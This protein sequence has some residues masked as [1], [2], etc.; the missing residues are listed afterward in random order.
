MVQDPPAMTPTASYQIAL[1][2]PTGTA[3]SGMLRQC[4]NDPRITRVVAVTRRSLPVAHPKLEEVICQDFADLEPIAL[5]LTHIDACFYALGIS[6][7]QERN[8]QRY[9]QI[10]YDYALAAAQTLYRHSPAHLF[11]FISG[12]G[13]NDQSHMMWARVKAETET[14]LQNLD[15]AGMVCWRPS[16]IHPSVP[17]TNPSWL[18]R[19]TGWIYPLL[20]NNKR[21]SVSSDD[22]GRAM[23]Q[24]LFEDRRTGIIE[25]PEIR[26]LSE[27]YHLRGH[28]I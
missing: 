15:L 17:K 11:Y 22:L 7:T 25:N 4:L 13:T 5:R 3:G 19:I 27:Q 18:E 10:T 26:T 20:K 12:Q 14:S 2:G 9:R 28:T 6:Q 21:F 16:Y 8:P 1:F 24:A 23:L